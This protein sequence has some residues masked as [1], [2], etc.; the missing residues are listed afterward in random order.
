MRLTTF[1]PAIVFMAFPAQSIAQLVDR[2]HSGSELGYSDANDHPLL[3]IHAEAPDLPFP[4]TQAGFKS[5]LEKRYQFNVI[6]MEGCSGGKSS[7]GYKDGSRSMRWLFARR[8]YSC[9]RV[10]YE[11]SD[12][13]GV[14]RCM[15][16]YWFNSNGYDP[17][18]SRPADFYHGAESFKNDCRWL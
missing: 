12:P 18:S 13:R 2:G 14:K 6:S 11:T 3:S 1:L 4:P 5:Y 8:G 15:G 16:K 9:N 17:T 7:A 10:F